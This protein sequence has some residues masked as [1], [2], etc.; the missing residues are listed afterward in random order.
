[1]E[2]KEINSWQELTK[3]AEDYKDEYIIFRGA[4]KYTYELIPQIGRD[5][6]RVDPKKGQV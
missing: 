3:I 1:M 6:A 4:R 5:E 2:E